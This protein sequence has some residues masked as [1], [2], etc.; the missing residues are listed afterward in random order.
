[1][2]KKVQ[3]WEQN[4]R[5]LDKQGSETGIFDFIGLP[6]KLGVDINSF[7]TLLHSNNPREVYKAQT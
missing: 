1:M 5:I 3:L 7:Q 2:Y 4:S 6:V